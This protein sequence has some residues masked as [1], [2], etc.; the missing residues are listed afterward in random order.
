VMEQAGTLEEAV[1]IMRRGPRTCE[2]YYVISDGKTNRAVGIKATPDIFE[3]VGPGEIHPQLRHPVKDTVLLSE[4]DRYLKL[5]ERT[6]EG[7]GKLDA[8]GARALMDP[9]VCMNSNIHSV[10]FAP[11]ALDFWVANADGKNVA[12][13][14]R[15]T[16]YN[17]REL[18][19][20]APAAP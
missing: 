17:L 14:T 16:K 2:Y 3:V 11:G 9:P 19:T 15:Y 7:F 20:M 4:G 5:V 1:A 12:S 18:L 8:A 10:L 13:R 6:R